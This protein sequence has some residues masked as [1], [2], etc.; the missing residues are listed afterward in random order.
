ML[1][2]RDAHRLYHA[3]GFMP[4]TNPERFMQL[5]DP[6]VYLRGRSTDTK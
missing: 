2:T 6:D 4:L 3:F 5:H 1:G